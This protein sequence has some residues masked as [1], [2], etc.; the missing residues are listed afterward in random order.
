MIDTQPAFASE[1]PDSTTKSQSADASGRND[2]AW[3]CEAEYMRCVIDIAPG[4]SAASSDSA[5]GRIDTR[6]FYRAEVDDQSVVANSQSPR[7]MTTAADRDEQIVLSSEAH[8]GNDVRHVRATGNQSRL[9]VDHPVVHL[10]G[11]IVILVTWFD[12]STTKV[13]FEIDYGI[14]VK[15]D[16]VSTKGSSGQDS[17][18]SAFSLRYWLAHG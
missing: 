2:S 11:F 5:R 8:G 18:V 3:R 7:V 6:I 10:A 9:F 16:E 13:C 4:A 17:E 12:Q 15:N 14:L 1:M